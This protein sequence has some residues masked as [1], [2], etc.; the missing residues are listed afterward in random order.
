MSSTLFVRNLEPGC[1][2]ASLIAAFDCLD[3][4][5]SARLSKGGSG[6]VEFSGISSAQRALEARQGCLIQDRAISIEHAK[7]SKRP[8]QP[9]DLEPCEAKISHVDHSQ[10]VKVILEVSGVPADASLREVSHLFRPFPGFVALKVEPPLFCAEFRTQA[11][12]EVSLLL[13]LAFLALTIR[14][15]L[16]ATQLLGLSCCFGELSF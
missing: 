3:G 14:T 4:Y 10:T 11:Q 7:P 15:K 1:L 13:S 2:L 5:T 16:M 12:S 8:R 6:F 9:L